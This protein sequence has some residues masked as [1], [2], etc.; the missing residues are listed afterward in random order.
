MATPAQSDVSRPAHRRGL[1]L[2]V[3]REH[4]AY[5]QLLFPL[6]T[7]LAIGNRGPAALA[8]ASA[9]ILAFVA[10]ESVL[11]LLGHRGARAARERHAEAVAWLVVCVVF[12]AVAGGW[13]LVFM[14]PEGR[15]SL[16]L[17][18]T[19]ALLLVPFIRARREHSTSGEIVAA[20]ALS[21]CSVPVAL[22]G[23]APPAS[24]AWCWLAFAL[25]FVVATVAVRAV[26][27]RVKTTPQPPNHV[28]VGAVG[29]APEWRA[30][31]ARAMSGRGGTAWQATAVCLALGTIGVSLGCVAL[32]WVPVTAGLAPVPVAG[33]AAVVSLNPPHPRHLRSVGWALVTAT[34]FTAVML[35][36]AYTG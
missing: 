31:G 27:V 22:A 17:P 36:I 25:A 10:H 1:H 11:V 9:C 33:L 28:H 29:P 5:G 32:E 30:P 12:A 23:G 13:A 15:L 34:A 4:G 3:P 26:I 14:S 35:T 21:S 2:L 20:I 18:A 24:A 16:A 6:A 8:L 7:A 19:L